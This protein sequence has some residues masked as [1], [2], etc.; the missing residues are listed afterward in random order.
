MILVTGATGRV[1]GALVG[2]LKRQGAAVRCLVRDPVRARGLLGEGIE[3]AQGD[4]DDPVSLSAAC[5]GVQAMFLMSPVAADLARLQVGA[6]RAALAAGVKR[7]VKLSGSAW[8]LGRTPTVTGALHTEV[9][10]MLANADLESVCLRPNAFAQTSLARLP[11]EL[12]QGDTFGLAWGD[13]RVPLIDLRDIAEVAGHAL[14]MP[15]PPAVIELSGPT[16]LGGAEIATLAADLTGRATRYR[17]LA[18]ESALAAARGRGEAPF[19]IEHLHGVFERIGQ[20]LAAG[21][22]DGVA[23]TLGRPPRP[24]TEWLGEALRAR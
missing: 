11:A 13:G 3:L 24:L 22:A 15:E 4:L 6:V 1:G 7:V 18:A 17:P 12:A 14:T 23:A 21:P 19:V 2:V 16:D 9:E 8:T 10:A 5:A 20:G